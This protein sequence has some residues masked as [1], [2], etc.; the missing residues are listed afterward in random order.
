MA[1]T[2][3]LLL[4]AERIELLSARLY[5]LLAERFRGD[6]V[7]SAL[8]LKLEC[9]E[10]QH[11]SRIRLLAARYRHD[12]RLLDRLGVDPGVLQGLVREA[13]ELVAQVADGAWGDDLA[14]VKR[15][16]VEVELHFCHAH[17]QFLSEDGHPV[18][19]E[20]FTQLAEQDEA[21]AK[22]LAP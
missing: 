15:N 7:A 8:F 10:L 17:A 4:L 1:G 19:R 20:F 18:L 16:L 5:G 13:E 2:Y 21:H 22:L 6:E 14:E 3:E 9:E 12:G 11:G